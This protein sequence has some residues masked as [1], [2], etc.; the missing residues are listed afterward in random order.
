MLLTQSVNDSS[1]ITTLI[2]ALVAIMAAVGGGG[3]VALYKW[4]KRQVLRDEKIDSAVKKIDDLSKSQSTSNVVAVK[5]STVDT[6]TLARIEIQIKELGQKLD[7][8]IGQC[9]EAHS[10]F[11]R[12]TNELWS[13]VRKKQ[14]KGVSS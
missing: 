5:A 10:T 6:A 14:D 12:E 4:W 3:L 11:R 1:S 2:D 8:H 7:Q 13:T 9:D